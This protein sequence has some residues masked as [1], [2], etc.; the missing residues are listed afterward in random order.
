MF[1]KIREMLHRLLRKDVEIKRRLEEEERQRRRMLSSIRKSEKET[2]P[3]IWRLISTPLPL[4]KTK[5]KLN[6][7]KNVEFGIIKGVAIEKEMERYLWGKY[8][9]CH[10]VK[11]TVAFDDVGRP[12]FH[13]FDD[14]LTTD[15]YVE[16]KGKNF[17]IHP[18]QVKWFA[19]YPDKKIIVV[20]SI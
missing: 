18:S 17:E 4:S 12:D 7:F 2:G 14:D 19:T 15:F 6:V 20:F 8:P 5:R 13:V 3:I 10:V 1:K 16:F 9:N 11:T